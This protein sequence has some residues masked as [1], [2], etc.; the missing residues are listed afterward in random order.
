MRHEEDKGRPVMVVPLS[1]SRL[2][3]VEWR[4]EGKVEST[5]SDEEASG[6]EQRA[7]PSRRAECRY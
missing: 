7:S 2:G 5:G 3:Q 6:P 1:F 4:V